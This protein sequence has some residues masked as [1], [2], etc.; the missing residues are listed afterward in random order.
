MGAISGKDKK[1]G[2]PPGFPRNP[3]TGPD[4]AAVQTAVFLHNGAGADHAGGVHGR[5]GGDFRFRMDARQGGGKVQV[6]LQVGFRRSHV[7]PQAVV[8]QNSV[9]A[10]F[11]DVV[12][13]DGNDGNGLVRGNA[14]EHFRL[15]AVR[16][17]ELAG[18]RIPPQRVPHVRH[19]AGRGVKPHVPLVSV[20]PERQGNGRAAFHVGGYH[21]VQ[22]EGGG[23]VSVHHQKRFVRSGPGFYFLDAAAGIQQHGLMAEMHGTAVPGAFR[24]NPVPRVRQMMGVDDEFTDAAFVAAAHRVQDER[25]MKEGNQ[26][27]GQYIG[28]GPQAGAQS[29]AE[30][31]CAGY[32][33]SA[34]TVRD[35]HES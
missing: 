7:H 18:S 13:E 25:F 19:Q 15:H 27:L 10:A 2:V 32:A 20:R 29:G 22:V 23:G 33:G 28:Q 12:Q 17:G 31:E 21:A 16:S 1:C 8:R 24:K 34:G 4:D 5:P 14:S 35:V 30:D 6:G 26:R 9:Q 11:P 3:G